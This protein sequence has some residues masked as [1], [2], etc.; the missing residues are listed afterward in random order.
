MKHHHNIFFSI[1]CVLAILSPHISAAQVIEDNM[2]YHHCSFDRT[3]PSDYTTYDIDAQTLHYTMVQ[4]GFKQGDAWICKKESGVNN[5]YAA[6][7][8]KYKESDDVPMKPSDDWLITPSIWIRGNEAKLSWKGTSICTNDK[9]GGSYKVMI[10]TTGNTPESFT[11]TPLFMIDEESIDSWTYHEIDLGQYIG[12]H[13]YIAFV[14]NSTQGELIGIDDIDITGNKGIC[15]LMVTTERYVYGTTELE[16]KGSIMAY[17]DEVITDIEIFYT[18]GSDVFSHRVSDLSLTKH[19]SYD[20]TFD[21]KIEFQYG[22]TIQYRVWAVVNNVPQDAI[23]C[24]S[25][26]LLFEPQRKVVVEEATGMWCTYCPEG[27][28]AMEILKE[29]YPD[30]YIGLALHYN[31]VLA[32]DEYVNDLGFEGGFPSGWFNRKYYTSQPMILIDNNGKQEY[33]AT[34]GGFES[35]FVKCLEEP[36]YAEVAS[37][38]AYD[39]DKITIT[40]KTRFAKSVANSN[41][42][43]AYALIEDNVWEEGYYQINKYA[44]SEIAMGGFENLPNKI[45]DLHFDHVVRAIYDDWQGVAGSVPSTIETGKE[46][47]SIYSFYLPSTILNYDN[48]SLITMLIDI[49]TGE[50]VNAH[51]TTPFTGINST[52]TLAG[53][54]FRQIENYIIVENNNPSQAPVDVAVYDIAGKVIFRNLEYK[55]KTLPIY[56]HNNGIYLVVVQQDGDTTTR[57]IIRK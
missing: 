55:G 51:T 15:E 53:I 12:E 28:V 21:K 5:Y 52:Q 31:D 50:I 36:T 10:S 19:Q 39:N 30:N 33:V 9:V 37:I 26:S 49:T 6:S 43:I 23:D 54:T 14:N 11:E 45:E 35:Y 40:T 4:A 7:A 20:Y 32:V 24:Q 16:V 34:H 42:Q 47:T 3:I 46:Y 25:I 13:I 44:N 57:K 38:V 22:D 17:S 48:V 56:I 2:T 8:C 29:K 27:I 41:Y 18:T 1:I